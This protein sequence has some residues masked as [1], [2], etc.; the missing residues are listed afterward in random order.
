ML[1]CNKGKIEIKG[2]FAEILADYSALTMSLKKLMEENDEPI[3]LLERSFRL[4]MDGIDK[5]KAEHKARV[6]NSLKEML[7]K[8]EEEE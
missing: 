8:L 6:I 7:E 4:G 1:A 3:S 2:S 5:A